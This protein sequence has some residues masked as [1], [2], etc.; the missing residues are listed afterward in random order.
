MRKFAVG[1]VVLG[2]VFFMQTP[3]F[4]DSV[5]SVSLPE[6]NGTPIGSAGPF[7]QPSVTVG[8]F[9]FLIPPGDV[10]TAAVLTGT[11]GNSSSQFNGSSAGVDVFL[12]GLLVAQC[13]IGTQC[14]TGPGPNA[15]SFTL[16][17]SQLALL[18]SGSATLTAIQTSQTTIR[19]GVTNLTVATTTVVPEPATL[20]MFGSGIAAIGGIMRRRR[21]A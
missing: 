19:L 1:A 16:S 21:K 18:G 20:I 4:A 5:T 12:N 10:I 15:W 11:F 2:L 17:P 7:P 13:V 14:W 6:F 3:A 9:T 8:I